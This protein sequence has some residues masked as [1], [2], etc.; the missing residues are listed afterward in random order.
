MQV[1]MQIMMVMMVMMKSRVIAL[2]PSFNQPSFSKAA[3]RQVR[4]LTVSLMGKQYMIW[5][6]HV[7][8]QEYRDHFFRLF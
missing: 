4:E 6:Y 7:E 8:Q 2:I 5:S 3:E 1:Q